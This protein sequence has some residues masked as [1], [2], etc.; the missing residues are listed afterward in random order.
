MSV[1]KGLK[2]AYNKG[3]NDERKNI[4]DLVHDIYTGNLYCVEDMCEAK[5]K[6]YNCEDCLY[7]A[8]ISAI[9]EQKNDINT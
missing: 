7:T 4:K 3:R 8:I 6:G 9:K 2:N 1:I 5:E